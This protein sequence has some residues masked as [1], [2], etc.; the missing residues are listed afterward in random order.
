MNAGLF[1]TKTRRD[2][3]FRCPKAI[4]NGSFVKLA[5]PPDS[6][7]G[8]AR[9]VNL[10]ILCKTAPNRRLAAQLWAK[11]AHGRYFTSRGALLCGSPHR[12]DER[13]AE[14]NNEPGEP[15]QVPR[16]LGSTDSDG[17]WQLGSPT[18]ANDE[19][20][21]TITGHKRRA[22]MAAT[23]Q[24]QQSAGGGSAQRRQ[25]ERESSGSQPVDQDEQPVPKVEEEEAATAKPRSGAG[26]ASSSASKLWRKGEDKCPG[27][28]EAHSSAV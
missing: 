12:P 20:T 3:G 9:R 2:G 24:C 1:C 5:P 27:T 16:K 21:Q 18:A 19:K 8:A 26:T 7:A 6:G 28:I 15:R 4:T 10:L 23:E 13:L 11:T 14:T 22:P 17:K 25:G